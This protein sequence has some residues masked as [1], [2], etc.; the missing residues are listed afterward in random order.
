MT[1]ATSCRL[2][3]LAL[4]EGAQRPVMFTSIWSLL[5]Q[6]LPVPCREGGV[7]NIAA[8]SGELQVRDHDFSSAPSNSRGAG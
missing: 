3:M 5:R 1:R 4:G 6:S 8:L 7:E 2:L